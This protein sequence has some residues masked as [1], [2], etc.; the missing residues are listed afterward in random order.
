MCVA[1]RAFYSNVREGLNLPVWSW[2]DYGMLRF[3]PEHCTKGCTR[4]VW[5]CERWSVHVCSVTRFLLHCARGIESASVELAGLQHATVF[6]P[7][8]ARGKCGPASFGVYR[9]ARTLCEGC[10]LEAS[11]P[12]VEPRRSEEA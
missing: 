6:C 5:P 1:L 11:V 3:L 4:R 2:R 10:N 8:T 9:A 12:R 7:S